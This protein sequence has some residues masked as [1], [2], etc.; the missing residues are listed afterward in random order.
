MDTQPGRTEDYSSRPSDN[1]R[2]FLS[3][4][5]A[6]RY[7]LCAVISICVFIPFLF[8]RPV[9]VGDGSEYYAMAVA[10]SETHHPYMTEPGWTYYDQLYRSNA[11]PGITGSAEL[12]AFA[13]ELTL[14]GGQDFPHFW[15]SR[16][17]TG[18]GALLSFGRSA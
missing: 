10:L 15:F 9:R 3:G 11:I 2:R 4:P 6:R 14:N 5:S 12:R 8:T 1:S 17:S 13:P 18:C 16:R 7:L